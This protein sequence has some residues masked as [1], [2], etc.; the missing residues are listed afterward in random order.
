[1][2][3]DCPPHDDLARRS[4]DELVA[5]LAEQRDG[6]H[7]EC[8]KR[9]L[10]I[11]AF[12]HWDQIHYRVALK[13]P[14]SDVEDVTASVIESA[15]SS[16]FDG[17][18]VGQFVSWLKTITQYRIA[19]Y[20]RKRERLPSLEPLPEE[21]EGDEQIWGAISEDDDEFATVAIREAAAKVLEGRSQVHEHVIRLY[22]PNE[23]NFM[24]Y[25]AAETAA[26]IETA[27]RG[28]TMSEANVHQIWRRFKAELQ[29]ELGLE[30]S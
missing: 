7:P 10:E 11:L 27:H 26:E 8:A 21:H 24:G 20:Y 1:M 17:R 28:E 18:A 29:D 6:G 22:G 2:S 25:S 15:I 23:L 19:D 12:G 16:S 3:D 9:A 4:S 14:P 5:Y 30:G 13:V